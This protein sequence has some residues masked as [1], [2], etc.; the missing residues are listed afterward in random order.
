MIESIVLCLLQDAVAHQ[1]HSTNRFRLMLL[2]F[3]ADHIDHR[4]Y[5][6]DTYHLLLH[7]LLLFSII[8][9]FIYNYYYN[10]YCY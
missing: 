3:N 2:L 6:N 4:K 1:S 8:L 9:L 7:F 10:C 5:D